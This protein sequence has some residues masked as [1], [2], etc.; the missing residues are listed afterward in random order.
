M[1]FLLFVYGLSTVCPRSVYG[2]SG[3]FQPLFKK[4]LVV[5]Y[6]LMSLPGST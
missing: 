4:V 3:P 1:S 2:F 5:E 6:N